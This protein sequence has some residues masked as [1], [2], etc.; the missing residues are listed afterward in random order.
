MVTLL[1]S[2]FIDSVDILSIW[3]RL[4]DYRTYR[5]DHLPYEVT[6]WWE[7]HVGSLVLSV[8][9]VTRGEGQGW[10]LEACNKDFFI[11]FLE[12]RKPP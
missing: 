7:T 4:W 1:H 9:N 10:E 3:A 11:Q 8:A 5:G 12:I 2:S 6:V